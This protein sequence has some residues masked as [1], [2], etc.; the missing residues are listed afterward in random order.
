MSVD[1]ITLRPVVIGAN[2]RSSSLALRDALFIDDAAQ[3]GFLATLKA[4][5]LSQMLVIS[6]C[7]RV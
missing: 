1:G 7:D 3:A 5:G 2:H 6:T 4:A